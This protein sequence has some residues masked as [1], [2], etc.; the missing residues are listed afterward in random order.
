MDALH[1]IWGKNFKN[2][3]ML[4]LDYITSAPKIQSKVDRIKYVRPISLV[5]NF[6]KLVTKIGRPPGWN[7]LPESKYAYKKI[8]QDNFMLVDKQ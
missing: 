2:L 4:N 7:G 1:T 3:L 6:A 5:H 8:M